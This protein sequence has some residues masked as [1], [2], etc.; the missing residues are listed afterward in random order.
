MWGVTKNMKYQK[1]AALG[2]IGLAFIASPMLLKLPFQLKAFATKTQLE[3]AEALERSRIEQRK[4]SADKLA[5]AGVLPNGQKLRIRGYF[6]NPKLD[7]KPETTGWLEDETVFV[8]D[9]ANSCIGRIQNRQ[10]YWKYR[11][12]SACNDAPAM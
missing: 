2:L 10:W 7:P 8:Y 5:E 4:L 1:Q 6:D 11:V 9:S 3:Q 12:K